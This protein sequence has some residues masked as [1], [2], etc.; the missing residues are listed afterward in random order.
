MSSEGPFRKGKKVM[1]NTGSVR[2][3]T[4][5][6]EAAAQGATKNWDCKVFQ[7]FTLEEWE[8]RF[9]AGF[10]QLPS[11][12]KV[13]DAFGAWVNVVM[14]LE[15]WRWEFNSRAQS[16]GPG[17]TAKSPHGASEKSLLSQTRFSML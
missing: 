1:F 12:E 14:K 13:R 5:P 2:Q 8:E 10:G 17:A 3:R 11:W 16:K 9:L 15:V 4:K 7:C 6:D